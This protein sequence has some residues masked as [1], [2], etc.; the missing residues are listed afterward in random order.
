MSLSA[1]ASAQDSLQSPPPPPPPIND[2]TLNVV[3]QCNF[4]LV[5]GGPLDILP[6]Q[7]SPTR[8]VSSPTSLVSTAGASEPRKVRLAGAPSGVYTIID[9]AP[10]TETPGILSGI[11]GTN[12]VVHHWHG[13]AT[14]PETA[15]V[16]HL[17]NPTLLGINRINAGAHV[18]AATNIFM[19]GNEFEVPS[20]VG[21]ATPSAF[22]NTAAN[23]LEKLYVFEDRT[24]VNAF[25]LEHRLRGLLAAASQPLNE[26][27]G[28]DIK[29]LKIVT[30]D[31]GSQTLFCLVQVSASVEDARRALESF[32]NR[33]WLAHCGPVAGKLNFDFEFV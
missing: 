30:D 20:L 12:P 1:L 33:W 6:A 32:D 17:A 25:I 18:L 4:R 19:Y 5:C 16:G 9:D 14:L 23:E 10:L 22:V 24:A 15:G 7:E 28:D 21:V 31:E 13:H 29:T 3:D 2:G 26:A 27:F 11:L 8:A